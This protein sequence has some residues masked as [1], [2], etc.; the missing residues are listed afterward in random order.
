[1]TSSTWY[2]LSDNDCMHTTTQLQ[3]RTRV[4]QQFCFTV[5]YILS[6][7]HACMQLVFWMWIITFISL[8]RF[9]ISHIGL[10]FYAL[11]YIYIA[12]AIY[13]Y[14]MGHYIA[15]NQALPSHTRN[16]ISACKEGESTPPDFLLYRWDWRYCLYRHHSWSQ[17]CW[18]K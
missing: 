2:S 18:I 9:M 10:F 13:S 12:T 8:M 1:M 17:I 7:K 15:S 4:K 11:S 3:L 14:M 5:L 6:G 16:I